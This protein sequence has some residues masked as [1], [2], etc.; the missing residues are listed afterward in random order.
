MKPPFK[1]Y[2][3]VL[4]AVSPLHIGSG[5]AVEPWQYV[6]EPYGKSKYLWLLDVPALLAALAE[7]DRREFLRRC[8]SSNPLTAREW[9]AGRFAKLKA[10]GDTFVRGVVQVGPKAYEE[11][12]SHRQDGNRTNEVQLFVRDE[13]S[14][15]AYVPG[16]SLKGVVRTALVAAAAAKVNDAALPSLGRGGRSS[17]PFEAMVLG[18]AGER[19][20]NLYRDPLRQLAFSDVKLP[21]NSTIV[22]RMKIVTASGIAGDGTGPEKIQMYR[23]ITW[24]ALDGESIKAEG[25]LRIHDRLADERAGRHR[26]PRA[27]DVAS[28]CRACND[29]YRPVL[30]EE[31]GKFLGNSRHRAKLEVARDGLRDNQCLVRIGRHSHFEA[32]TIPRFR[33]PPSK[34]FGK[35]R[36]YANG[37]TPLGW[38]RLTLEETS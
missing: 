15:G 12:A 3:V 33:Q 4:E 10:A 2:R 11:L 14:G 20:P 31:I 1:R 29:F 28:L 21:E 9:L 17:A 7:P 16:S 35:T 5:E 13:G 37:D 38:A 8:D 6:L 22:E 27:W 19:G 32:M 34:G 25:E 23:E 30:T 18:H 24:S 36:T 26:L